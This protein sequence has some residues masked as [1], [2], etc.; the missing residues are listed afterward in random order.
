MDGVIV[1]VSRQAPMHDAF[2]WRKGL[3]MFALRANLSNSGIFDWS[4]WVI[5][6]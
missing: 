6:A 1:S 2:S 5:Q 4:F 3:G